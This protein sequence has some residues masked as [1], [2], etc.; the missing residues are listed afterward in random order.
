M[1]KGEMKF[2]LAWLA[3]IVGFMMVVCAI[4]GIIVINV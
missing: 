1:T 4:I 3:V 2:Y